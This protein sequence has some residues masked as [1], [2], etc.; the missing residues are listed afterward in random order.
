MTVVL[1]NDVTIGRT[2]GEIRVPSSALSRRHALLARA[3]GHILVSD[4]GS[5]NGTQLR[6][7]ELAHPL[8]LDGEGD[9]DARG[10]GS[11]ARG[12]QRGSPGRRHAIEVAGDRFIATLGDACLGVEDWRLSVASDGWVELEAKT[13]AFA[14]GM[15]LTT[16]VT[17]LRGMLLSTSGATRSLPASVS[18]SRIR[19]GRRSPLSCHGA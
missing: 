19:T 9:A 15:T 8:R 18:R 2:E 14:G 5:R 10:R 1:A 12:A 17:L 3:D 11:A 7:Q 16:P 4:L 6:G 13:A